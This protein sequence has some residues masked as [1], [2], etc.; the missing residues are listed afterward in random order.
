MLRTVIGGG[1]G[2]AVGAGMG[3]MSH[4][5]RKAPE[6]NKEK[7]NNAVAPAPSRPVASTP[8]PPHEVFG[9]PTYYLSSANEFFT[10]LTQ[11]EMLMQFKEERDTFAQAIGAIDDLL[12]FETLLIARNPLSNMQIPKMAQQARNRARAALTSIVTFNHEQRP[13]ATKQQSMTGYVEAV[14]KI[15][16]KIIEHMH[17]QQAATTVYED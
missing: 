12:G 17:R 15:M 4:H 1:I 10:P 3:Y 2:A 8:P 14:V 7:E 6:T 9:V 5:F 16:D 11:F 13:S